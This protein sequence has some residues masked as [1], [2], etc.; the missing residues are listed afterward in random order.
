M[1][2]LSVVVPAHNE[3]TGVAA[4]LEA[5]LRDAAAGE[6][7]V[8]VVCNGCTDATADRAREQA[9]IS[10]RRADVRVVETRDASKVAALNLGD[11]M[12]TD[13]PRLYLDADVVLDTDAARRLAGALDDTVLATA[14][15]VHIDDRHASRLVRSYLR[16][17]S[18]LPAVRDSL[19]GRGCFVLSE[20]GRRRFGPFPE[21]IADD[22]FVD[23]LFADHER[24][25]L[26]DVTSTLDAPRTLGD[27]VERKARVFTGNEQ[28]RRHQPTGGARPVSAPT[29]WLGVVRRAPRRLVD[30]PAYLAVTLEARRRARRRLARDDYGWG[31]PP[32]G[33]TVA[34]DHDG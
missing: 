8:V 25:I 1:S 6:L 12:S 20:D 10:G 19:A 11:R 14:P 32:S 30:V 17:W 22:L 5:L 26:P 15:S 27:L 16:I 4:G 23:Q 33:E 28:L 9:R 29:A 2:S 7:D 31:R 21:L 13:F 24:R 18:E 3:A 34:A